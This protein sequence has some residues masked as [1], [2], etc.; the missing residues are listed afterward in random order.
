MPSTSADITQ[1]LA[2]HGDVPRDYIW[3]HA[4]RSAA[5]TMTG[6]L[7]GLREPHWGARIRTHSQLVPNLPAAMHHGF[8][9]L[10][11]LRGSAAPIYAIS[12]RFPRDTRT[13]ACRRAQAGLLIDPSGTRG[14]RASARA[15]SP[16][17]PNNQQVTGAECKGR[18]LEYCRPDQLNQLRS[19]RFQEASSQRGRS[20]IMFA[21]LLLTAQ[22]NVRLNYSRSNPSRRT[23]AG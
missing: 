3:P 19:D 7:L 23:T 11:T 21:D 22:F 9:L 17:A 16:G 1:A 14:T 10:W 4:A 5:R 13:M 2:P 8:F 18:K 20:V 6:L 12:G 15:I